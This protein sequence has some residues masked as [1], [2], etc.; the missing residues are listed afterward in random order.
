MRDMDLKLLYKLLSLD[1]QN[2]HLVDNIGGLP[3]IDRY[4]N[5]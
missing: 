2:E 3:V 5:H 4:Y 1:F